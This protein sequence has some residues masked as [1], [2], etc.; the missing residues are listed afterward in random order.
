MSQGGVQNAKLSSMLMYSQCQNVRD[1][2]SGKIFQEKDFSKDWDSIY[3]YP[4][5]LDNGISKKGMRKITAPTLILA[6]HSSKMAF[7]LASE[8]EPIFVC[9][10]FKRTQ[11]IGYTL[12]FKLKPSILPD[13]L[14]YLSKYESW[15]G[16]SKGIDTEDKYKDI[17]GDF[18]TSGWKNVGEIFA[19]GVTED[20]TTAEQVFHNGLSQSPINIPS[21]SVQKQRIADAI[22]MEKML[23]EKMA[24]KGKHS[25]KCT[26][27]TLR[28]GCSFAAV[29][30]IKPQLL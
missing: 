5:D 24:E 22:A 7:V 18:G 1:E 30:T 10:G 23:Q 16:I 27:Y 6:S 25:K 14:F 2:I 12:L 28:F 19:D 26:F 9:S 3:V 15:I 13:Y 29:N 20:I 17:Y 8:D 4:S 11:T 21:I